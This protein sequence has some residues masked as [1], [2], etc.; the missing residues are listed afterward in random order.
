MNISK[1]SLRNWRNF[2]AIDVTLRERMFIVGPNASGK[3]NLLDAIRF[4]RHI[5][6]DAGGLQAAIAHRGGLGKIRCLAARSKPDVEIDLELSGPREPVWRYALGIRTQGKSDPELTYERVWRDDEQ[7]LDRPTRED[8]KDRRR[9]SQTHL[10]QINANDSFRVI[11]DFFAAISYRHL[12]PQLVRSTGISVTGALEREVFGSRFIEEVLATRKQTRDA[13][14]RRIER[15]LKQAVPQL[16]ELKAIR[17]PKDGKSHLEAVYEHWRPYG[18][19]QREDQ[20]SDGTLRMIAF[21]WALLD[22][23]SPLLLE[24]P[25]ISLHAEIVEQLPALIHQVRKGR[26]SRR[27]IL[28]TTHSFAMLDQ[29]VAPEEVLVLT[30][31]SEG[32]TVQTAATREDVR[33]MVDAGIPAGEAVRPLTRPK[34]LGQLS[35]AL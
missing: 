19:R 30:P 28:I 17:D 26:K 35:F 25:E 16:Q 3:S 33:I 29:G 7:L 23:D 10:E 32:T 31:T 8:E 1:L 13:R 14:L 2:Q 21:F 24:E 9:L 12:V 22:G 5:T 34:T 11:A 27:Q 15:A 18:A 20:F 4:L 6:Q